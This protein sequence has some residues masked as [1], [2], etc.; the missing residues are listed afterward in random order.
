MI[1]IETER[2]IIRNFTD[3]DID[4]LY[5]LL[6]NPTVHCFYDM[7]VNNRGKSTAFG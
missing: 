3:S 2:L 1:Y 7:K 4:G 6:H 5:N